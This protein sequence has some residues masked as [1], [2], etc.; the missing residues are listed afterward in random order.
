MSKV[1]TG[2]NIPSSKKHNDN[3]LRQIS[4]SEIEPA[5][6][7]K[8]IAESVQIEAQKLIDRTS[9]N[10][11]QSQAMPTSSEIDD[12]FLS[13]PLTDTGNAECFALKFGQNYRFNGT[14]NQWLKWNG[15]IWE[16]D[17]A[18]NIDTDILKTV[19]HRRALITTRSVISN[20]DLKAKNKSVAF[21]LG[22]ENVRSRKNVKQA[23]QW[24]Q[25]LITT[26][27]DYDADNFLASA[28]NG[29]LNLQDGSFREADRSDYITTQFGTN[30]DVEAVCP[31]WNSFLEEIFNK[32]KDLIRFMQKIIGYSLTGST[33]EQKMFIFFGFGKNGKTVFIN[34]INAL[35]GGYAGSASFKTFDADKQSEQTNDLA[36]LK[37]KRFVSMIES[38][39]DR[40]L[41][42]PL[43]KQVTGDDKVTCR[44]LHK[45]YFEYFPQ[46]KL[47]LATNHKP[48][49]TQSDF[50]IW[51]RILLIP[52][53]QNFEDKEESGLKE[54][55]LSELPGILNWALEGLKLWRTEG[56]KNVP[57][58]VANT[59]RIYKDDSDTVGQW[60]NF[61]IERFSGEYSPT[62]K[63]S[64]AY[65]DYKNWVTENGFF[66]VGSR[67]F[68]SS[69]EEKGC[70]Y[71]RKSDNTYW[72]GMD[73]KAIP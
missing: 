13:A 23:A 24:E 28:L 20:E 57:E 60:L 4:G 7:S 41:N 15:V 34:T 17:N 16:I 8:I 14:N 12:F 1:I 65:T 71:V 49:I 47:F 72:A 3:N 67:T 9:K 70:V 10:I 26:I 52:F 44:F 73:L 66:A 59:T 48:V 68:K 38:A 45:E 5:R 63:S 6:V 30:F 64:A 50:G 21:F 32:D 42:E 53:T 56:L 46:F 27:G 43:I 58:A 37:G 62:L 19:R 18:S 61:R 39:A 36:M 40:K 51:R 29:T 33:V 31:R 2:K 11:D 35:L 69:L 55:L 54:K 22:S 25:K